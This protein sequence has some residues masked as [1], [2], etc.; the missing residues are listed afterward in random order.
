MERDGW[1][2]RTRMLQRQDEVRVDLLFASLALMTCL[3]MCKLALCIA[4]RYTS[5]TCSFAM[6]DILFQCA[7]L[8]ANACHHDVHP[9]QRWREILNFCFVRRGLEDPTS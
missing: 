6:A 7:A 3:P 1:N 5:I 9:R 2:A 4:I 8:R